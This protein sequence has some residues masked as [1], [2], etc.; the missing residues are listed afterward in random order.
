MQSR[1]RRR[2][3][4]PYVFAGGAAL[5][6]VLF[7]VVPLVQGLW[8]SLTDT[9][10]LRPN[11]GHFVGLENY[12]EVFTGGSVGTSIGLTLVYAAGTVAGALVIG[13]VAALAIN[14][15]FPGRTVVRGVL[16][17]PWAVPAVAVAL[18]FSWMYNPGN[19]VVNQLLEPFGIDRKSVV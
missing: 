8:L 19:G 14:T 13:T 10:L 16:I 4:T 12:A 9:Q 11:D 7:L 1:G 17:A 6:L 18:V 2:D 3:V 15:R 5:Y